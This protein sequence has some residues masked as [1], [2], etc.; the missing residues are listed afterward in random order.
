MRHIRGPLLWLQKKWNGGEIDMKQVKTNDN[1]A[2]VN[3]KALHKERFMCLLYLLGFGCNEANVG[4]MEFSK[5][6]AKELL[7]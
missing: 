4:E 5:M 1:I 2:D 6:E 7:K 3:A